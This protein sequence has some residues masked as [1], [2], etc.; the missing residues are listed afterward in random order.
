V[1]PQRIN[2]PPQVLASYPI[3]SEIIT[4]SAQN[5]DH[6]LII[7]I[8]D[9][10]TKKYDVN[11]SVQQSPN[12]LY[13]G[14]DKMQ[15]IFTIKNFTQTES[16]PPSVDSYQYT[17]P[18][19]GLETTVVQGYYNKDG[20]IAP[21]DDYVCF[22]YETS[23]TEDLIYMPKT[24]Q[25][26]K[27]QI[28]Y[29]G[30][31]IK[32]KYVFL[33]SETNI[34]A[35][36]KCLISIRHIKDETSLS[37]DTYNHYFSDKRLN[38]DIF[39]RTPD[40]Q[41]TTNGIA[42]IATNI[43]YH[44]DETYVAYRAAYP[45]FDNYLVF[46]D[47][48]L[49]YEFIQMKLSFTKYIV[50]A[51]TKTFF[52]ISYALNFQG[53][54]TMQ[55]I[56]SNPGDYPEIISNIPSYQNQD[57]INVQEY[58]SSTDQNGVY[59]EITLSNY[60]VFTS[61]YFNKNKW[62]VS[63]YT[64]GIDPSTTTQC[65]TIVLDSIKNKSYYDNLSLFSITGR[66][67]YE[68]LITSKTIRQGIRMFSNIFRFN[69]H[70]EIEITAYV[71][72]LLKPTWT[73][74]QDGLYYSNLF[75]WPNHLVKFKYGAIVGFNTQQIQ[76]RVL[77]SSLER[78]VYYKPKPFTLQTINDTFV[79]CREIEYSKQFYIF[80]D[81]PLASVLMILSNSASKTTLY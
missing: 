53:A 24:Q 60:P 20:N 72:V 31:E 33:T 38:Y 56:I 50:P 75:T 42:Q 13:Y 40:L 73:L 1:F 45:D 12:G 9:S 4:I 49:V 21:S 35:G 48:G 27:F 57:I 29:Q 8:P 59:S 15:I 34:P 55:N 10:V 69:N 77:Y 25:E 2:Q 19:R 71:T 43:M 16:S 37:A 23:S 6:A 18:D 61:G 78:I 52:I 5:N 11:T 30:L 68:I 26:L 7:N 74:N 14:T 80:C 54:Q 81:K 39:V 65:K 47:G 3:V 67:P 51:N 76:Y 66:L 36:G 79:F 17:L 28:V 70:L 41:V 62:V 44:T 64:Q 46:T 63:K 22:E 32:D 58:P